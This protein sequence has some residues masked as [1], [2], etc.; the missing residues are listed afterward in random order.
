MK[1]S[2]KEINYF[3]LFTR[4]LIIVLLGLGNLYLIYLIATPLTIY[5]SYFLFNLFGFSPTLEG[6]NIL[7]YGAYIE[8]VSACIA[9]AAYFLLIALNLSTPMRKETRIKSLLFLILSF[10]ILNLL[11]IFLF[12]TLFIKGF[13]YF[14]LAHEATWYFGS[15]ILLLLIWFAN[16]KIFRIK[17][18]PIYSDFKLIYSNI[19]K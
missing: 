4:Y 1:K 8:L 10:F 16:V 17:G 9:G 18:I 15:T 2:K 12:G 13:S 19:K 14:D 6:S 11:R 3:H 5:S 7:V